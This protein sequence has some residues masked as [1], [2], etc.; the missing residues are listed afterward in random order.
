MQSARQKYS[1]K[2]CR[3]MHT[4]EKRYK[5]SN[6]KLIDRGVR[7]IMEQIPVEYYQAK[8]LLLQNNSVRKAVEFYL[9]NK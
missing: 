8:E 5:L 3:F 2:T 4:L 7:M 6:D 1:R 9:N